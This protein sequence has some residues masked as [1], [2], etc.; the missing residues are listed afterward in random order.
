MYC[1]LGRTQPRQTFRH[2]GLLQVMP[3]P[4]YGKMTDRDLIAIYEYLS[5]IPSRPRC[6]TPHSS[7]AAALS[8]S[9]GVSPRITFGA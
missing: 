4:V 2:G 3:W 1:A 6:S 8:Q 9:W 7:V 5:A